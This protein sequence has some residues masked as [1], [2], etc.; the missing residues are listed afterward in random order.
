MKVKILKNDKRTGVKKGEI[1]E[2]ETY[3]LDP[4]KVVLL[5]R[6]SD[7]YEPLCTEYKENIEFI[8]EEL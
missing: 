5:R 2:A 4:E 7:D 6:V 3:Y 8:I 1:Y